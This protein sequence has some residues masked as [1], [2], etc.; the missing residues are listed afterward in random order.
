MAGSGLGYFDYGIPPY[1]QVEVVFS[2]FYCITLV[3][4]AGSAH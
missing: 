4:F 2:P 1:G 3:S